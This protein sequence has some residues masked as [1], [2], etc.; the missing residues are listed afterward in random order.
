MD[1][2]EFVLF[3]SVVY[4]VLQGLQLIYPTLRRLAGDSVYV[5]HASETNHAHLLN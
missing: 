1:L 3:Y 5:K 4:L 2:L